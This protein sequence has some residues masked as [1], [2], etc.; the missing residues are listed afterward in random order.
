[1]ALEG[2]TLTAEDRATRTGLTL[3]TLTPVQGKQAS[4]EGH[5][6]REH[7][8]P[9]G[10]GSHCLHPFEVGKDEDDDRYCGEDRS[11]CQ[12]PLENCHATP[13]VV[14]QPGTRGWPSTAVT[15]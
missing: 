12:E 14:G 5:Q 11:R 6:A 2:L 3:V 9:G 10:D 13:G 1:M 15:P 8:R 4:T 7:Q